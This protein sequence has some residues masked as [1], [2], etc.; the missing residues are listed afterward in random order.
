[1]VLKAKNC[2]LVIALAALQGCVGMIMRPGEVAVAFKDTEVTYLPANFSSTTFANAFP[3]ELNE[4][5]SDTLKVLAL[6]GYPSMKTY[7]YA[8]FNNAHADNSSAESVASF[9]AG[10]VPAA[11]KPNTAMA[12]DFFASAGLAGDISPLG[13]VVGAAASGSSWKTGDPRVDYSTGLCFKPVADFDAAGALAS[14]YQDFDTHITSAFTM[15]EPAH[16]FVQSIFYKVTFPLAD[17]RM[18][19]NDISVSR[20]GADY[21]T[22]FMPTERGGYKAHMIKIRFLA[23]P[24]RSN[25]AIRYRAEELA[26]AFAKNKPDSF[27]YLISPAAD[28]QGRKDIEPFGIY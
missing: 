27:V 7:P 28:Q 8:K 21:S 14:C 23:I 4:V 9:Y 19:I 15:R 1:V 5:G 2:V 26:A 17:G 16:K 20:Y 24:D 12:S 25:K 6:L 10:N 3:Q 18:V 13:A 22:G 11:K